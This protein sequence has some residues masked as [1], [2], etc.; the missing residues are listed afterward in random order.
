MSV[1]PRGAL[2]LALAC[3]ALSC[4][5]ATAGQNLSHLQ[6]SGA[7]PLSGSPQ[8]VAQAAMQAAAGGL[9]AQAGRLAAGAVAASPVGQVWGQGPG[10]QAAVDAATMQ[11]W[12]QPAPTSETAAMVQAM[13]A[14]VAQAQRRIVELELELEATKQVCSA[15]ATPSTPLRSASTT[16]SPAPAPAGNPFGQEQTAERPKLKE[17]VS[18][19]E[20]P[21]TTVE[22]RSD[23]SCCKRCKAGKPCG[24]TCIARN[25][26]CHVGPGCAC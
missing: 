20:P 9:Q 24:D 14:Q 11:T 21:E 22:G 7:A 19:E 26:I 10:Y 15:S 18:V 12:Q 25:K 8:A 3:I 1:K 13:F 6:S 5:G 16:P 4:A 2:H 17:W 23:T